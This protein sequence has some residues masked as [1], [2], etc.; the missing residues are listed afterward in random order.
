MPKKEMIPQ[1]RLPGLKAW[2]AEYL[3][4][5]DSDDPTVQENMSVNLPR[6][7]QI[8]R[9]KKYLQAIRSALS[10]ESSR[11]TEVYERASAYLRRNA[12]TGREY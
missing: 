11:I 2:F 5:F 12:S 8:V 6:T 1:S 7:F 10:R 9:E 4:R 3:H